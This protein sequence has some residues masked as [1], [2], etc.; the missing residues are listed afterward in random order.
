MRMRRG[1]RGWL[2]LTIRETSSEPLTAWPSSSVMTSPAF[3]P[4]PSAG[5]PGGAVGTPPPGGAVGGAGS[6]RLRGG[7]GVG[8]GRIGGL[9]AEVGARDLVALLEPRHDL[10]HGVRRDGEADADIALRVAGGGDLR[11]DA[12]DPGGLVEQGAA[13][14]AGIDRRVGLDDLVDREPVGRLDRA[15]DAR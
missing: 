11:V 9:Y 15:P 7:G 13:R 12:H 14:V 3:T 5:P 8:V 10:A 1:S 2:V 6:G 4:A